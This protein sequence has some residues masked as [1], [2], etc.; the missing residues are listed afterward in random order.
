MHTTQEVL[1]DCG[2]FAIAYA[3]LFLIKEEPAICSIDQYSM[4]RLYNRFV[5]KDL[6]FMMFRY[7]QVDKQITGKSCK[8]FE[9]F[10]NF[11]FELEFNN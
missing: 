2:L 10:L 7:E 3:Y 1:N 11:L 6:L 4:R 5:T 8:T 9:I